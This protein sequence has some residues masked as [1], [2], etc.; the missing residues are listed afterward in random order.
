MKGH[1][2]LFSIRIWP[3]AD[4]MLYMPYR[5]ADTPGLKHFRCGSLS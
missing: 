3:F 1:L 2:D 5:Y 4:G